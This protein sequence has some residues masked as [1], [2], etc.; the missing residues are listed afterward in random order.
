MV[1]WGESLDKDL[2]LPPEVTA[3]WLLCLI[4]HNPATQTTVKGM[5]I[6]SLWQVLAP[7]L[8][9]TS[10]NAWGPRLDQAW[11]THPRQAPITVTLLTQ[12]W[13]VAYVLLDGQ[14]LSLLVPLK[15]LSYQP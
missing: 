13:M 4:C 9:V 2:A 15:R 10:L 3:C 5:Y 8:Q 6:A 14:D 11:Y 1:P 12:D 7:P